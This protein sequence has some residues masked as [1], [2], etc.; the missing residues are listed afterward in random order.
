S[1]FCILTRSPRS[2]SSLPML[3]AVSPLP[4]LDATPPVTN[5][6]RVVTGLDACCEIANAAPVVRFGGISR[7][8]TGSQDIRR[9]A[10]ERNRHD[11]QPAGA[12]PQPPPG[13]ACVPSSVDPMVETLWFSALRPGQ[14]LPSPAY[15]QDRCGISA[16]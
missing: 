3:E 2:F 11:G 16:V 10:L 14:R 6:C 15:V 4:R 1:S 12:P 8:P 5:K 13:L 9:Q 7:S